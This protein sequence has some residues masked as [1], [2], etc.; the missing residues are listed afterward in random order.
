M[1]AAHEGVPVAALPS[2]VWRNADAPAPE[3]APPPA[4][5]DPAPAPVPEA[6]AGSPMT[7]NRGGLA[8]QNNPAPIRREIA[9]V[10]APG[11]GAPVPPATIP[12]VGAANPPA[13]EKSLLNKLFGGA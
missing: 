10:S 9:P 6:S 3:N 12:N 13:R 1:K 7:I 8:L 2:G 4:P 5:P 11:W